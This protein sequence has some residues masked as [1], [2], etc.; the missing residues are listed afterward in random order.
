MIWRILDFCNVRV[1]YGLKNTINYSLLNMNVSVEK[2]WNRLATEWRRTNKDRLWRAHSDA[3]NRALLA[4]WLPCGPF[5]R[6]LK[7]DLFDEAVGDGLVQLLRAHASAVVGIDIS[8][9]TVKAAGGGGVAGSAVAGDARALPFAAESFDAIVSNSTLD[10]FR[11]RDE[12]ATALFE[13]HRVLNQGGQLI[14]TMD[15]RANPLVGLRNLLPF[16]LIRKLNIV[17][18]YVGITCGPRGLRRIL[19]GTGFDILE[20]EA[21]MHCPRVLAVWIA[22]WL[23]RHASRGLQQRYLR[24]LM[25]FE[26]LAN[27]P[28]RYLTGYFVAVKAVKR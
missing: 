22:R 2:H 18:Y 6:L 20:T 17:N 3:V 26:C 1:Y 25:D 21:V 7:T 24:W 28:T 13:L 12:L 19:N 16:R 14:I 11:T 10:H 5:S 27:W 15:N 8:P 4:R 9:Q 23:Q